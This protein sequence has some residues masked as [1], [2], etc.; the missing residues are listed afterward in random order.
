MLVL[1]FIVIQATEAQTV[2]GERGQIIGRLAAQHQEMRVAFGVSTN[3][4]LMEVFV[5]KKG[6]W[7]ITIT[8]PAG[9]ICLIAVGSH[10]T[11]E[12]KW[13]NYGN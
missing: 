7:T 2:C 10:W 5:S 12:G 9:I 11:Q 3:G 8:R 6:S 1:V 13:V 4:D